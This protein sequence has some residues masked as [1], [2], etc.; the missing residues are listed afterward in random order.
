LHL[1]VEP[2]DSPAGEREK[3]QEPLRFAAILRATLG[4]ARSGAEGEVQDGVEAADESG[5]VLYRAGEPSAVAASIASSRRAS[6]VARQAVLPLAGRAAAGAARAL[7]PAVSLD[8][9]ASRAESRAA[10][11]LAAAI[12]GNE[13]TG[14]GWD[15]IEAILAGEVTEAP[16]ALVAAGRAR[17]WLLEGGRRLERVER[18]RRVAA[19]WGGTVVSGELERVWLASGSGVEGGEQRAL[20]AIESR[21]HL[22]ITRR[23]AARALGLPDDAVASLSG[24]PELRLLLPVASGS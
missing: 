17:E 16:A 22:E 6:T 7:R 23:A 10:A 13:I 3:A 12:P 19:A 9:L 5:S 2:P 4:G 15:E 20:V 11:I 8:E 14:H 21:G 18:R 24:A 1:W